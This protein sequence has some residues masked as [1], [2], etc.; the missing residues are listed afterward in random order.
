MRYINSLFD[1]VKIYP[2]I[3]NSIASIDIEQESM[4]GK[5][6]LI[7]ISKM[8]NSYPEHIALVKGINL[9]KTQIKSQ[10][11]KTR[12]VLTFNGHFHDIPRIKEEFGDCFAKTTVHIDL[13][14]ISGL[15]KYPLGLKN[16][17][18]LFDIPRT[19]KASHP[20]YLY[21]AYQDTHDIKYLSKLV[22][23]NYFD[24]INLHFLAN[25]L[26]TIAKNKG[27]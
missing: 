7:G 24:T 20:V 26:Y 14:R 27:Y 5:I 8:Y 3:K 9:G 1:F 15:L 21:K 6:S 2:K 23:Y 11:K 17:E 13:H 22:S 18:K 19:T 25:I 4:N 10:L 16:L 12:A